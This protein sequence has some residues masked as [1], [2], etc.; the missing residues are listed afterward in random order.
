LALFSVLVDIAAR[1]ASAE[2]GIKRV[3]QKLESF[4]ET[5]K[6]T[7]AMGLEFLGLTVAVEQV[8]EA[9]KGAVEHGE[10][11]KLLSDRLGTSVED[12]SRLQYAAQMTNVPFEALTVSID[13]FSKNLGMA[14]EGTGRAKRAFADLGLDVQKLA[15]MPFGK[16]METLADALA[17]VQNPTKRTQYELQILSDQGARLDPIFR[18]GAEAMRKFMEESDA[19]GNTVTTAM[20]EKLFEAGDAMKKLHSAT[21]GLITEL[22]ADLAPA[23]AAIEGWFTKLIVGARN[24]F[25][26]FGDV[27]GGDESD[28]LAALMRKRE[29]LTASIGEWQA[30]TSI[31]FQAANR[32]VIEHMKSELAELNAQIDTLQKDI[33]SKQK[34]TPD[35]APVKTNYDSLLIDTESI[36]LARENE[37]KLTKLYEQWDQDTKTAVEKVVSSY[38]LAQAKLDQLLDH[39]QI[40]QQEYAKRSNALLDETLQPVQITGEKILQVTKESHTQMEAFADQAARNIQNTFAN[41]LFDPFKEGLRGMAVEF[42]NII[43]RMLAEAASAQI[44]KALFGQGQGTSGGGSGLGGLFGALLRSAFGAGGSGVGSDSASLAATAGNDMSFLD[45][46][47]A[48]GGYAQSGKSYLVG[49]DGPEIFTPGAGGYVTPNGMGGGFSG[50]MHFHTTIDARGADADRVMTLL[51]PLLEQHKQQVKYEM[52]TAFRRSGLPAPLRA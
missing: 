6:E 42:I 38:D 20:G 26:A 32:G 25:A 30:N 19:T 14:Q 47:F 16:Q 12:I 50:D 52:L 5:I 29:K 24:L 13:Q 35:K 31:R 21:Q 41:F 28:Q 23:L 39:H 46:A 44:L 10:E 8:G 37:D 3:E 48:G 7:A 9:I 15:N 34:K 27:K 1:T 17:K 36:K 49:E 33:E 11:L 2:E 22:T 4:G 40:T 51:P 43:R 18:G 45:G